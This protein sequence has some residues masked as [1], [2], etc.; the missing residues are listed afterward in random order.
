MEN[1]ENLENLGNPE[2]MG[3]LGNPEN[4]GYPGTENWEIWEIQKIW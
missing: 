2:N 1:P 3:N 4:L